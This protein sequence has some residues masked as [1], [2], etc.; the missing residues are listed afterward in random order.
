M[1]LLIKLVVVVALVLIA[2]Y[3]L[4]LQNWDPAQKGRDARAAI[5]PGMTWKTAFDITGD[6]RKYRPIIK[7]SER[8]MG[9]VVGL[10]QPGAQNKFS[11]QGLA[12][13][14]AENSLPYGFICRFD[15]TNAVAF[16][17][18]FDSTGTVVSVEDAATMA[19]LLQYDDE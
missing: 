11:R 6:P 17:V 7:K 12:D 3:Y 10:L 19:T 8:S 16:T 5:G 13:R 15:Y 14:L 1:K 9:S 18:R 2:I 4:S